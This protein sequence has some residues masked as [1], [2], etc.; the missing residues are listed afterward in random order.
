MFKEGG[1]NHEEIEA[2]DESRTSLVRVPR[3]E[4]VPAAIN[5]EAI[6][7]PDIVNMFPETTPIDFA[8]VSYFREKGPRALSAAY[9]NMSE[10]VRQNF[11][12]AMAERN[13]QAVIHHV[14][15]NDPANLRAEKSMHAE[16]EREQD[17]LRA[18][19]KSTFLLAER[20][21]RLADKHRGRALEWQKTGVAQNIEE[22]L[23]GLAEDAPDVR[24][25]LAEMPL[26]MRDF[27]ERVHPQVRKDV[28]SDDEL[29]NT[30]M[31]QLIKDFPRLSRSIAHQFIMQYRPSK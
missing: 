27:L 13:L 11:K 17:F 14:E 8:V 12:Q 22:G 18:F 31:E 3:A 5:P 29:L 6:E 30:P 16:S 23:P 20:A 9:R 15:M 24:K 7:S 21:T 10:G 19:E 28:I 26:D 1:P 2:A 4:L 25:K